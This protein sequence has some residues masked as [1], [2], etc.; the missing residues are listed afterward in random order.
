MIVS[1]CPL[2]VSLVGGGTDLQEFVDGYG[3]GSVISFPCNLYS[4]INFFSDKN[5]INAIDKKYIIKYTRTEEVGSIEEIQNDVAKVCLEYFQCPPCQI[6]FHSDI[7]SAGSG[8]ASSS[9]Y[10]VAT[11]MAISGY[12]N[13]KL[14]F[15][16]ICAIALQLERKFNPLTGMQDIYGCGIGGFKRLEFKSNGK[17]SA[18]MYHYTSIDNYDKYLIYTGISRNSTKILSSLDLKKIEPL[19]PLVDQF[20]A[21]IKT[22]DDD[23][24]FGIINEAWAKKKETSPLIT[25]NINI[26][27]LDSK[28]NNIKEIKAF[29]LCGAGGGGYFLVFAEKG[30]DISQY[31]PEFKD[32]YF[33]IDIDKHGIQ[34]QKI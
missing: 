28:L 30:L 13:M 22:K 19:L 18:N 9:A 3:Y 4:Y 31:L 1:K 27:E 12:Y 8:L 17:V 6:S 15:A 10:M 34:A 16:Q 25:D 29:K 24:F 23:A 2:R 11:V 26:R 5:G 33:K 21:A 14:S 20:E 7:S 32:N